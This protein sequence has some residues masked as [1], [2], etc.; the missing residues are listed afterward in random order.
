[1]IIFNRKISIRSSY[2]AT[3]FN[4]LEIL[5]LK[6]KQPHEQPVDIFKPFIILELHNEKNLATFTIAS[7]FPLPGSDHR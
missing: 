3:E 4:S 7:H 1:M 2:L 6:D 5:Q